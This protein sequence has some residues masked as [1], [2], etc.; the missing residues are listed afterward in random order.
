MHFAGGVVVAGRERRLEDA[1]GPRKAQAAQEDL[2]FRPFF[3]E[4]EPV[5]PVAVTGGR[6]LL[7]VE[8]GEAG[9]SK[10]RIN[11]S[12]EPSQGQTA[13]GEVREAPVVAAHLLRML[14]RVQEGYPGGARW[15]ILVSDPRGGGHVDLA[16]LS[17]GLAAGRSTV[18]VDGTEEQRDTAGYLQWTKGAEGGP[19]ALK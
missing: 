16:A 4:E 14:E 8:P 10:G 9:A 13:A 3:D 15:R 5:V 6:C 19:Q 1:K 7:E 17:D 2:H 18:C 11:V 12:L